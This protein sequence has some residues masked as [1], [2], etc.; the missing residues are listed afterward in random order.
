MQMYIGSFPIFIVIIQTKRHTTSSTNLYPTYERHSKKDI[1]T[2]EN[3]NKRV[4][5]RQASPR[6]KN[7]SFVEVF[8]NI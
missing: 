2:L 6:I 1:G 4:F 8:P 3:I 7:E 5:N